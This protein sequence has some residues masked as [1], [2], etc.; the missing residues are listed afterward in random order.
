MLHKILIPGNATLTNATGLQ[1]S[2]LIEHIHGVIIKTTFKVYNHI[3]KVLL[4]EKRMLFWML[5][6]NGIGRIMY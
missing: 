2:A 6:F 1:F 4:I 3:M 5:L